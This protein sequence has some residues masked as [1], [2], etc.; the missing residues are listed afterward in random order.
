MTT[1]VHSFAGIYG[2]TSV[3]NGPTKTIYIYGG[4]LYKN[5]KLSIS[6]SLFTYDVTDNSWNS[7]HATSQTAVSNECTV[8]T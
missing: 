8:L 5:H 3:Y 2:H 1:K 6:N 7:L 4:Y